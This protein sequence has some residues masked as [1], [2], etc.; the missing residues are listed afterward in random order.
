MSV[1]VHDYVIL[2][3][4]TLRGTEILSVRQERETPV[5]EEE[6]N[7]SGGPRITFWMRLVHVAHTA[8]GVGTT[9]P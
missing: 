7:V 9:R 6:G 4:R 1:Y 3:V 2:Q 5:P 8:V